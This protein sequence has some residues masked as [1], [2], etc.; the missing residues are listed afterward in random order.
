ME[1]VKY[2]LVGGKFDGEVH[3]FILKSPGDILTIV[4]VND[5]TKHKWIELYTVS[6]FVIPELPDYRVATI[7]GVSDQYIQAS[8]KKMLGC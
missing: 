5:Y 1:R 8:V 4:E 7:E 3:P 2:F 6:D